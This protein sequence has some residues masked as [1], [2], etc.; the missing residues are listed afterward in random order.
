MVNYGAESLPFEEFGYT[1]VSTNK[2]P[3][4][5]SSDIV[6]TQSGGG[7][8][9]QSG[10]IVNLENSKQISNEVSEVYLSNE[11]RNIYSTT[12]TSQLDYVEISTNS[13]DAEIV[14]SYSDEENNTVLANTSVPGELEELPLTLQNI[15]EYGYPNVEYLYYDPKKASYKI[16]LKNLNFSNGFELSVKN[17]GSSTI[18]IT[19]KIVGRYYV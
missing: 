18:N 15:V 19:T 4:T 1:L 3:I 8:V 5:I 16:A 17:S 10:T 6:P 2:T 14:L 11:E 9:I 7:T 13:V 12:K